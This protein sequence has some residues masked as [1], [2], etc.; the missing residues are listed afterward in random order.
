MLKSSD[1][2]FS[3]IW[4]NFRNLYDFENYEIPSNLKIVGSVPGKF[5]LDSYNPCY[6]EIPRNNKKFDVNGRRN[7][8]SMT[9]DQKFWNE[10]RI[11]NL[12]VF[13]V[14]ENEII[15]HEEIRNMF[16]H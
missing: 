12:P 1:I 3:S 7:T 6:L 15:S 14:K 2:D 11:V 5:P 13:K 9:Q 8:I 16:Q 10:R 4:G